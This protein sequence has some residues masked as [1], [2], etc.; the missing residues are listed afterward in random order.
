MRNVITIAR[1]ELSIYF[2]TAWGWFGAAAMAF[3]SAFFFL[4]LLEGFVQLQASGRRDA[5]G[6][7]NLTDGVVVNLF[8]VLLF[9]TLFVAPFLSMRLFAEERRQKT[10]ELLFTAPVRSLEIVLGKYLGGVGVIG[11][12]LGITLIYPAI[13]AVFGS[14][15]SGHVLEWSTVFTGYLALM[16]WASTC[17]GIG[18]FISALTESQALAAILTFVVLLLWIAL[19]VLVR[20]VDE[21]LRSVIRY[22]HFDSQLQP[23][24]KGV[25]DPKAVVFFLSAIVLSIVLTH[26][27]VEAQRWT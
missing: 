9:I 11:A 22:V 20:S 3:I 15:E 26:R 4:D 17:M 10:F 21:P 6:L 2:T 19:G 18:M 8:G 1:K 24:M 25:F 12:I 27:A 23:L 7:R 16:L 13:L 5:P 14:S